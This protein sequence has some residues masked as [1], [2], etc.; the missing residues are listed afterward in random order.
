MNGPQT[1]GLE[2]NTAT[3][4]QA[5]KEAE[6]A[7]GFNFPRD[8][9]DFLLRSNGAVGWIGEAYLILYTIE[10]VLELDFGLPDRLVLFGSDGGGEAFTFDRS[11]ALPRVIQ[12]PFISGDP[13]HEIDRGASF[14]EFL[15]RLRVEGTLP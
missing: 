14:T 5:V 4:P 13:D 6:V 11:K 3:S 12:L 8:Y 10:N 15:Q 2:L 9:V 1:D 7:L